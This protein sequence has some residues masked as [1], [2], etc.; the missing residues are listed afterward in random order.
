VSD[1]FISIHPPITYLAINTVATER[2]FK[3]SLVTWENTEGEYDGNPLMT[4]ASDVGRRLP[5]TNVRT[6]W[7]DH[8]AVILELAAI[9]VVGGEPVVGKFQRMETAGDGPKLDY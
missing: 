6:E 9:V 5:R 7:I 4:L 3:V 2:A 1:P 8:G